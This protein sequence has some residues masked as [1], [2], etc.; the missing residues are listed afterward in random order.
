MNNPSIFTRSQLAALP[1]AALVPAIAWY[2]MYKF[3]MRYIPKNRTKRYTMMYVNGAV[4][5]FLLGSVLAHVLPN[6]ILGTNQEVKFLF[7]GIGS[8]FIAAMYKGHRVMVQASW[9]DSGDPDEEP[10]A[11]Q[12]SE[13]QFESDYI[14]I[15][16]SQSLDA[17][18]ITPMNHT[19]IIHRR[20]TVK[21]V[22]FVSYLFVLMMEGLMLV[23]NPRQASPP[24][25]IASY[26]VYK[27]VETIAMAGYCI[28]ADDTRRSQSNLKRHTYAVLAVVWCLVLVLSSIPALANVDP[29]MATNAIEHLALGSFYA[30]FGGMILYVSFEFISLNTRKVE[31]I[32]TVLFLVC[33]CLSFGISWATGLWL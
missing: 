6:C 25:L 33:V 4:A 23:V 16:T 22:L 8:I 19:N 11:H 10:T 28:H 17:Q 20:R 21:T 1:L 2:A 32:E 30:L 13:T 24:S 3:S 7:V 12:D 31:R 29:I 15:D 27:T 5:G 9:G 18:L 14:Q 26:Y